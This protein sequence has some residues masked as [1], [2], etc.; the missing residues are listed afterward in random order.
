MTRVSLDGHLRDPLR[1][2]GA[3][4]ACGTLCWQ[5]RVPEFSIS[6][7]DF[8]LRCRLW[9]S[10]VLRWVRTATAFVN[11]KRPYLEIPLLALIIRM[12]IFRV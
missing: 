7:G 10:A 9:G 2:K 5:D 6:G 3:R 8:Y 1:E 12:S 4:I 11:F